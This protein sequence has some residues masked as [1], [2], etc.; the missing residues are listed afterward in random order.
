MSRAGKMRYNVIMIIVIR[1]RSNESRALSLRTITYY[2]S[3]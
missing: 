3:A 2:M 1:A